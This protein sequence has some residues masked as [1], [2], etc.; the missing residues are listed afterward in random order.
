MPNRNVS[1]QNRSGTQVLERAS[2]ILRI[3]SRRNAGLKL[4]EIERLAGLSH[5]TT[6]RLLK[7]L[8]RERFVTKDPETRRY[9]L[10]ILNYELGLAAAT[11]Y[12]FADSLRPTLERIRDLTGDTIY[13]IVRSGSDALYLDVVPGTSPIRAIVA[14]PG[15]RRPICYSAG[16]LAL[17]GRLSTQDVYEI[18]SAHADEIAQHKRWT[19]KHIK[20][21][22][23]DAKALGYAEVR[24]SMYMGV[25]AIAVVLPETPDR[26]DIAV[27]VGMVSE[28]L[29]ARKKTEL[30]KILNEV[31]APLTEQQPNKTKVRSIIQ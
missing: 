18:L 21:A 1:D 4:G 28:R 9:R 12:A 19:T 31:L 3:V 26:P 17:L 29:N 2:K 22:I 27:S 5:P 6:H 11:K 14:E 20:Q 16:G 13:L 8:E 30:F 7:A 15:I 25:S 10:G 24:N 23:Q